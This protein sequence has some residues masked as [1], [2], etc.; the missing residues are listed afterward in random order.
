M[1]SYFRACQHSWS[2]AKGGIRQFPQSLRF[3]GRI[4]LA[5]ENQQFFSLSGLGRYFISVIN[6][7][8]VFGLLLPFLPFNAHNND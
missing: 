7:I 5:E 8:E 6:K 4:L 3:Y 2:F 1:G